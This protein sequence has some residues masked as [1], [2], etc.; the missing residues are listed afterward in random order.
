MD[1]APR[2]KKRRGGIGAVNA[3]REEV[4]THT[5]NDASNLGEEKR[6][7][8]GGSQR[9]VREETL[10]WADQQYISDNT[11]VIEMLTNGRGFAME[12][13]LDCGTT[14]GFTLMEGLP[15]QRTYRQII[16]LGQCW[17]L[18]NAD[19]SHNEG[20]PITHTVT[21]RLQVKDQVEVFQ[22][23]VTNTGKTNIIIGFNWLQK[24][25]PNI[26]WKMGSITLN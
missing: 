20:G 5:K 8:S 16:F 6:G 10:N 9:D 1:D 24:H 12:P 21:L 18:Y 7:G 23:S 17:Y 3:S 26:N 14:G 22:F 2:F 15:M 4:R 19:G 25:N 11:T 13:L